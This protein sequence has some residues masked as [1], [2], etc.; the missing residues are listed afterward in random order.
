[1]K[2]YICLVTACM[3]ALLV[4][5]FSTD[6]LAAQT[7]PSTDEMSLLTQNEDPL[8]QDAKSYVANY[9]VSLQEALRRLK[10]QDQIGKL[11]RSLMVK[12]ED[13]YAGLWIQH[14]PQYKVIA[15]FTQNGQQTIEPYVRGGALEDLIEVRQADATLDDLEVAQD[16]LV[17]RVNSLEVPTQ[18]GIDVIRNRAY[19]NVKD[20][21]RLA[22]ALQ[23]RDKRLP[24]QAAVVEVDELLKP[25][26]NIFAG[27]NLRTRNSPDC[28]SGFSVRNTYSG[29][30][31]ITTAA[32]CEDRVFRKGQLL[33][34]V[35]G[36]LS[37]PYDFQWH[38]TPG[39]ADRPWARDKGGF[40]RI[41]GVGGRFY[42]P[43]G[44]SVCHYGQG[45]NIPE[46]TCGRIRDR[47][48]GGLQSP[49][50]AWNTYIKVVNY[51]QDIEDLGD[52]GGPWY[53][54]R[55]ALGI[56]VAGDRRNVAA[57]MSVAYFNNK[58]PRDFNL[59]VKQAR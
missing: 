37:G 2:Y 31:G 17:E 23:K 32:H 44:A 27:V 53:K 43:I 24:E 5:V 6:R 22:T 26:A 8:V 49:S 59:V 58:G 19:V 46:H 4:T 48:F 50:N 56:H 30:S 35:D 55:T 11:D 36:A 51:N 12:E 33:R 47:S 13:T 42:L 40:R 57:Y 15:R 18:S 25:S 9:G 20:K 10:L 34:V 54:G 14:E 7:S 21:S 3:L 28:T 38:V 39:F 1:M 29:A 52:S 41:T 45:G 16:K